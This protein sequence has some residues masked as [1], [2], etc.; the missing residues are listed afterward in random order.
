[1]SVCRATDRDRLPL[2]LPAIRALAGHCTFGEAA[3][4]L[5]ATEVQLRGWLRNRALS[6]W[7]PTPKWAST[8]PDVA[9]RRAAQLHHMLEHGPYAMERLADLLD[10]QQNAKRD[11]QLLGGDA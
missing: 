8:P 3:R 9:R 1:M 11:R 7:P 5:G 2:T 4:R 6:G 10:P